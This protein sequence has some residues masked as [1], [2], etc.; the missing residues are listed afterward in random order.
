MPNL[1]ANL[2]DLP[3]SPGAFTEGAVPAA[4]EGAQ[5]QGEGGDQGG[6]AGRAPAAGRRQGG[7][8]QGG[9]GGGG[10][11]RREARPGCAGQVGYQKISSYHEYIYIYVR[12]QSGCKTSK[13]VVFLPFIL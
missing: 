7:Q 3:Q 5:V 10:E 4:G 8:G 1:S 12:N 6:G 2:G 11:G 9:R 13:N